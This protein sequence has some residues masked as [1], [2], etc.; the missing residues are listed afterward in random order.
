[1]CNSRNMKELHAA[2]SVALLLASGSIILNVEQS[3]SSIYFT[4]S[5]Q[6][7]GKMPER[8]NYL[9]KSYKMQAF[10]DLIVKFNTVSN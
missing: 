4:V 5:F 1:M 3:A 8:H 10:Q 6:D 9:D 2:H 7:D